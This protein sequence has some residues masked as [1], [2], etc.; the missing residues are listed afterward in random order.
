[1]TVATLRIAIGGDDAKPIV[2]NVANIDR[3]A[4]L[5]AQLRE[6]SVVLRRVRD[7]WQCGGLVGKPPSDAPDEPALAQNDDVALV[8]LVVTMTSEPPIPP[9]AS[10]DDLERALQAIA[11]RPAHELAGVMI[12]AQLLSRASA[13]G[14]WP[15]PAL[16]EL[17]PS[18]EG[19]RLCAFCHKPFAAELTTCPGCGAPG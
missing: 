8:M 1:M 15:P 11:H 19:K 9:I 12:S 13:L 2:A 18:M 7:S 14:R 5:D 4:P 16:V 17:A 3:T 10:A 6:A